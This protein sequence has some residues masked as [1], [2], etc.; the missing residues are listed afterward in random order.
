VAPI[1]RQAPG[2]DRKVV[3]TVGAGDSLVAGFIDEYE[4]SKDVVKA[5]YKGMATGSATALSEWLATKEEVLELL[6]EMDN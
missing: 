3:N 2:Y 5:F 4:A 6:K 1:V